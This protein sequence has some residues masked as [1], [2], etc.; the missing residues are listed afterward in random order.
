M[1]LARLLAQQDQRDEARDAR[2][3]LRHDLADALTKRR[4]ESKLACALDNL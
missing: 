2:R 3:N 1:S 4:L